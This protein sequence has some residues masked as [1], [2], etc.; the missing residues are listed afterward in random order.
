MLFLKSENF[1]EISEKCK[2]Q[3]QRYLFFPQYVRIDLYTVLW[4]LI[5]NKDE[6]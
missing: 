1:I 5:D 2:K 4:I 3:E 6:I